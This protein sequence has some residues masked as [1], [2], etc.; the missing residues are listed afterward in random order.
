M[1]MDLKSKTYKIFSEALGKDFG[2][3]SILIT[4]IARKGIRGVLI[5]N[6]F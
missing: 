3:Q 1:G 5:K 2:L 6:I 4:H